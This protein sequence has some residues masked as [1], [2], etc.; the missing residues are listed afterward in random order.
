MWGW[1]E[2]G[3]EKGGFCGELGFFRTECRERKR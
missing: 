1:R 2:K 3:G